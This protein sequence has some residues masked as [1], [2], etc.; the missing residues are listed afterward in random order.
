MNYLSK[1]LADTERV[2]CHNDMHLGNVLI[3]E[4]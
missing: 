4:D 2:L 1:I 3:E